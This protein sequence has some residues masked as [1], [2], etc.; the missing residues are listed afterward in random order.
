MILPPKSEYVNIHNNCF[1]LHQMPA[2]LE[3]VA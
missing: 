1:H 3:I 2:V